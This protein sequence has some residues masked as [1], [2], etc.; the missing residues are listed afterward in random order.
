MHDQIGMLDEPPVP[1]G[2]HLDHLAETFVVG[3]CHVH[4]RHATRPHLFE[5]RALPIAVLRAVDDHWVHPCL[6][7]PVS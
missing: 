7:P 2:D 4:G 3:D 1:I 6:S 5:D